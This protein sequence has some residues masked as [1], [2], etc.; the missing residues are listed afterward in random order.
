MYQSVTYPRLLKR[1]YVATGAFVLLDYL[2]DINVRVAFLE[3]WPVWRA[4]YY[5]F[6]LACLGLIARRPALTLA[7]ATVESLVTLS[8]LILGMGIR[9]TGASVSAADFGGGFVTVEEIVNFVIA[10]GVA[11]SGW[12]RGSRALHRSL[13]P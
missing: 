10:G 8:A 2:A 1:Y 3:P 12:F 6:C 11:W 4:G 7:V 9:V 5:L 13:R